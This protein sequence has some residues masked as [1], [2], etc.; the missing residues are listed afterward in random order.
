MQ[1][2]S[3]SWCR[4]VVV[5]G[6]T[7]INSQ[8]IHVAVD[9]CSDLW[10][11]NMKIIAPYNSPNTDGILLHFSTRVKITGST[12]MTGDDCISVGQGT[13]DVWM[14]QIACGPGHGIR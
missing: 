2:I 11:R 3:F 12:I 1:S 6:L 7:S 13:K 8:T 10:I 4:K 9:H 5:T 14:E